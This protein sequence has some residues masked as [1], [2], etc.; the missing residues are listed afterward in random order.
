MYVAVSDISYLAESVASWE[1]ENAL[2][3]KMLALSI[4]LG[5]YVKVLAEPID[6]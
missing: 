3:A 4:Q 1:K 2:V 6:R 5:Y